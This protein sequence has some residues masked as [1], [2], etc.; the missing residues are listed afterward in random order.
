METGNAF[1]SLDKNS[2]GIINDGSELFGAASGNG[3]ADLAK[4][5]EDGNEIFVETKL[6]AG[7][8]KNN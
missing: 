7:W 3:F 4:Y 1:L 2:D 5:D 8:S 6:Y